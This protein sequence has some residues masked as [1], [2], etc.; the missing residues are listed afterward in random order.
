MPSEIDTTG[1]G[2]ASHHHRGN[3]PSYKIRV[4]ARLPASKHAPAATS[5]I[6]WATGFALVDRSDNVAM[7][8]QLYPLPRK[9]KAVTGSRMEDGRL[10]DLAGRV[11]R[12]LVD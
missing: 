7:I 10:P 3:S 4:S 2:R 6:V 11:Q 9:I 5:S 1:N 8:A 12:P